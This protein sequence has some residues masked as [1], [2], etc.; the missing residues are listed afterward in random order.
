M[1]RRWTAA[2]CLAAALLSAVGCGS[3]SGAAPVAPTSPSGGAGQLLAPSGFRV[4]AQTVQPMANEFQ[5]AWTSSEASF[6]VVIGRTSG[7][8]E[9]V[10]QTVTGQTFTWSSPREG[11]TYFARV[12]ARRGD[13]TSAFSGEVSL[14]VIDVRDVIDAMF[15]HA[16]ALSDGAEVSAN[17]VAGVWAD[18]TALR[19]LV[20]AAAGETA[21]ANAQIFADQYAALVGGAVTAVVETSSETFE[22]IQVSALAANTIAVRIQANVCD[23]GA[24]GCAT[25]GP[26]P[27]GPNRSIITLPQAAGINF[28]AV[29]HE[30]GHAYG[31]GHI[32]TATILRPELRFMMNSNSGNEQMTEPE[33][34]AI[35]LA[36]QAGL[37]AGWTRS[38]AA[39]AGL[40][41]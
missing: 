24:L 30:M 36:R 3:G 29:P 25:Y 35:T 17:P 8:S 13:A 23:G 6:Q 27:L 34:L 41:R 22:G 20:S 19:V 1:I 28:S 40:I 16:G 5:L 38:Q 10:N 11:G 9:L 33:K 14:V 7:G 32:Q 12:A 26:S 4:T 15:F 2:S 21:R 31:M 18:G 37:R 39:A